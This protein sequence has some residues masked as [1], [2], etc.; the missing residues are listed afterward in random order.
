VVPAAGPIA[1]GTTIT[2]NG[3]N[4]TSTASVTVG[5]VPAIGVTVL[6]ATKVRAVTPPGS[7]GGRDVVLTTPWGTV[8]RTNGFIY[9]PLPTIATVSP[10]VGPSTGGTTITITGTNF[11]GATSVKIGTK[12]ATG[13]V[14]VNPTTITAVTPVNTTGPKSVSVTTPGGTATLANGYTYVAPPTITS[15]APVAGPVAGGT[16]ITITGTNLTGTTS[17]TV[18]GVAAIGVTVVSATKV[19]AVTPPG[20]AGTRDVSVTTP[21]G[22]VTKADTYTYCAPPTISGVSPNQGPTTGGITITISG[23]NLSGTTS[24]KVGSKVAAGV[25]VV[26]PTAI[27]AVAPANTT[28]PKSVSVFTPGGTAS[29]ANAFTFFTPPNITHS[30]PPGGLSEGGGPITILGS[31]L[32][33]ITS[34]TVGGVQASF[35]IQNATRI[36]AVAPPGTAGSKSVSVTSPWGISTLPDCYFY[37]ESPI[38]VLE[39]SPDPTVVT[40]AFLRAAIV[41]TGLPWR[42]RDNVSH[43]EMLLVP[44]GEFVMGCSPSNQYPCQAGETPVHPVTLSHAFYVGRFEVT[45]S[46]WQAVMG[47]N[48][49]YFQGPAFPDAPSRPVDQVSWNMAQGFLQATGL[50]MLSEAEWEY[51]CRAGTETAFHSFAGFPDGTNEDSLLGNIAWFGGNSGGQTRPVGQKQPNALGLYDMLG[52]G[53]EWVNDWWSYTYYQSAPEI[54][55][56]GPVSGVTRVLRGG[57]AGLGPAGQCRT[58]MRSSLSPFYSLDGTLTLRTARTPDFGLPTIDSISPNAGPAD[59]GTVITITGS[60]LAGATSVMVGG[61]P[62]TGVNMLG[63]TQLTAVTPA[64]VAGPATVTVTTPWGTSSLE[65]G[66]AYT[67]VVT[68]SWATLIEATPDPTVVTNDTM[69]NAIISTGLAWRVR[70]N[71]SQIEMLLVPPGTFNMGCSASN[72]GGCQ[73]DEN[74]VHVVTLSNPFYLGRYEVTQAQWTAVMGSNPSWFVTASSEVPLDQVPQR[75]VEQ[76]SWSM[77]QSFNTA[78]GLRLPT[79]AEWEFAYRAGTTTAFHSFPSYLDGFDDDTQLGSIAW[80]YPAANNRTR[81]VGGRAANALGLHDMSGNVAEWVQDWYGVYSSFV[82]VNPIGPASGVTR[83]VRGGSWNNGPNVL[84]ASSRHDRLMGFT[85]WD[86]GFR[87]ARNP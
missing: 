5:G 25:T 82:Q 13:L 84:R 75:P 51:A 47:N 72:Q 67:N 66:F 27:T 41:G 59:G 12:V 77:A 81:P 33:S 35:T 36:I 26:S 20:S 54:D 56:T 61:V 86:I 58:S 29:L 68:P 53:W 4:L 38:S 55:P 62:A 45:Q 76:I 24:V 1:G 57:S 31:G 39:F 15:V 69:R 6:S 37:Y 87:V 83:V 23:T 43:I 8:T 42:V 85:G 9:F 34:V 11:T 7:A 14:V 63:M 18:G 44:P 74:P 49:S 73:S 19:T 17:V 70:D 64:G 60:N 79:E 40:D 50:R 10:N 52:N 78:T 28:G 3:A 80:L 21:W 71:A 2:I 65:G 30:F 32:A 46:Q 48:P 16:T 22:T